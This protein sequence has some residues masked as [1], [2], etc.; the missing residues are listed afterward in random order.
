LPKSENLGYGARI[1]TIPRRTDGEEETG[2]ESDGAA[3]DYPDREHK[4]SALEVEGSSCSENC[5]IYKKRFSA[6]KS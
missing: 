5:G 1:A 3:A 4:L 6:F 2:R